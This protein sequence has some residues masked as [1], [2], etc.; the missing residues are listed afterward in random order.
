LQQAAEV[1]GMDKMEIKRAKSRQEY[2]TDEKVEGKWHRQVKE[3][4]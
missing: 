3:S 1:L 2:A 4:K